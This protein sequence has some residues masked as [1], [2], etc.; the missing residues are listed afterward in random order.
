MSPALVLIAISFGLVFGILAVIMLACIHS[1][2][3]VT[4]LV[5]LAV[6]FCLIADKILP[7]SWIPTPKRVTDAAHLVNSVPEGLI[8]VA[9]IIVVAVL[10]TLIFKWLG[11]VEK[12]AKRLTTWGAAIA[13]EWGKDD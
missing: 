8:L 4:D 7:F 3:I 5:F 11:L 2:G 1:K 13:P 6:A 9:A 12:L 10:T